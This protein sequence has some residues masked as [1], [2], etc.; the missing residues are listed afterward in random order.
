M[1]ASQISA[2]WIARSDAGHDARYAEHD[3][4]CVRVGEVVGERAHAGPGQVAEHREVGGEG[5]HDEEEPAVARVEVEDEGAKEDGE[6][7]EV[8]TAR[9]AG[10]RSPF[11]VAR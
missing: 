8:T 1:W 4:A 9:K 6:P 11:F 5:E 2:S 3:R 7:L 10:H